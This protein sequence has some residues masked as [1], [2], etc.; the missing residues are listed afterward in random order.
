M[1]GRSEVGGGFLKFQLSLCVLL[2]YVVPV[3]NVDCMSY[4]VESV[5]EF[6]FRLDTL[7]FIVSQS[8]FR[9]TQVV[10][11]RKNRINL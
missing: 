5:S 6:R 4:S 1:S 2:L 10:V 9:R 8:G 7:Y 3:V 11:P